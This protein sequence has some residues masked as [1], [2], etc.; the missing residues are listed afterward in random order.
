[1]FIDDGALKRLWSGDQRVYLLV[2]GADL[3]HLKE[4]LAG[5]PK[6]VAT[7]GGNYLLTNQ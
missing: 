3:A 7:S 6:V 2:Y 5:Q 1:V 4:L